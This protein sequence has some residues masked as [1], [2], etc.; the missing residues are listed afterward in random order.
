MRKEVREMRVTTVVMPTY[1][2]SVCL[3]A[4][5]HSIFAQTSLPKEIVIVDDCSKDNTLK[6]ASDLASTSPVPIRIIQLPVNSGGPARPLNTG[7]EAATTENIAVLE[8]DDEMPP[9]RLRLHEEALR[10]FPDCLLSFGRF[11]L[12]GKPARATER[13]FYDPDRQLELLGVS[14]DT[15]FVCIPS[16]DLFPIVLNQHVAI[17]NSNL[18]FT[19]RLWKIV[20]GFDPNVRMVSDWKFLLA[21]S[22]HSAAAFVNDFCLIYR[23]ADDSLC[24][25]GDDSDWK[26]ELKFVHVLKLKRPEL[27][28]LMWWREYWLRRHHVSAS[29]RNGHPIEAV[30]SIWLLVRTGALLHHLRNRHSHGEWADAPSAEHILASTR[31]TAA[32]KVDSSPTEQQ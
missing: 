18:Y 22:R 6:V 7:I 26:E 2:A 14:S 31:Q 30:K 32:A 27:I 9:D 8:Q 19:K 13:L 21:A 12:I 29:L 11:R 4:S 15:P 20:G 17:S 25:I 5:L 23:Y 24:R 3:Q 1:N 28:G 10:R 16:S